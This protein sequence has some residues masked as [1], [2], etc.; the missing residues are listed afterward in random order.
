MGIYV[1]NR[2]LLRD[3]LTKTEH[4]DF[5]S[6]VFPATINSHQVQMHLFDGYWED[7]GTI[8]SFYHANLNMAA[9][10][11]EFELVD[12]DFPI[13]T[14]SRFL[15]PTRI[16]QANITRSLNQSRLPHS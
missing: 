13:Y 16:S 6:E 5:G 7:I 15:P 9:E 2:E 8:R 1:F 4:A 10:Q 12:P 14:R 11:P 3:V